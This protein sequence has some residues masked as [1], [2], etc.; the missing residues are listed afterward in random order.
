MLVARDVDAVDALAGVLHTLAAEEPLVPPSCPQILRRD[1]EA[2]T[3]AAVVL[4]VPLIVAAIAAP[5]G[6]VAAGLHVAVEHPRVDALVVEAQTAEQCVGMEGSND[7]ASVVVGHDALPFAADAAPM[8]AVQWLGRA[9]GKIGRQRGVALNA[10][11][12]HHVV[13]LVPHVVALQVVAQLGL[14]L[15]LAVEELGIRNGKSR[16]KRIGRRW[17]LTG[18]V[19][20][21]G[22][23]KEHRQKQCPE[24]SMCKSTHIQQQKYTIFH[25]SPNSGELLQQSLTFIVFAQIK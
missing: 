7:D 3:L 20:V 12:G 24:R 5:I 22:A 19:V 4:P 18:S 25:T 11:T 8:D 1:T 9:F 17:Q 15:R 16:E 21:A 14:N 23:K 13:A 2:E 10:V 6:A